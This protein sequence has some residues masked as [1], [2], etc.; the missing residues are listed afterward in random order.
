MYSFKKKQLPKK[1]IEFS[2]SIPWKDIEKEYDGSFET[3]RKEVKAEGFRKGKVPKNIAEKKIQKGEVYDH[4]LQT[5]VSKI[6][7][8]IL[9]KEEIKSIISPKV[10]L[11]NAKE[12]E[13]W[14]LV[15]T[16]A[17]A[18]EIV[19]GDYKAKVKKAVDEAKKGDIWVPGKDA[20]PSKEDKEK[21]ESTVFQAKL[22]AILDEAKA[23]ISDLIVDE[24][25]TKKLAK[26]VDDV[27]K[28]GLTMES[29]LSS[30]NTTQEKLKSQMQK[31]IEEAYKMEFVL[32]KIADDAKIQVE[33]ED[34]EKLLA[35]LKDPKDR[36]AA[37]QNMYYYASL[38]RKQ[39]TLDYINSL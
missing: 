33:K 14:E 20:E 19:L 12:H 17:E 9:K 13:D 26:L 16:T 10:E 35:S 31:E 7:S 1:T 22:S 5:F 23:E 38:M 8:E 36:E 37:Q 6:Y 32:Q 3:L 24:E 2:I 29:Y 27:Q 11:K 4:L 30:R 28:I 18:P 15:M 21:Q 39:K 25:V 34:I